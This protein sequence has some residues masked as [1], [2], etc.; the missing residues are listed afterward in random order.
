MNAIRL[1]AIL[2]TEIVDSAQMSQEILVLVISWQTTRVTLSAC[3]CTVILTKMD[4]A[5]TFEIQ[6][7]LVIHL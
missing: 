3:H 6:S 1:Y 7:K 2:T 5:M 4:A